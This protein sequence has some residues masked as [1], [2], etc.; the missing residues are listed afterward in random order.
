[1]TAGPSENAAAAAAMAAGQEAELRHMANARQQH[2]ASGSTVVIE[3]AA[4]P[5][6]T[7]VDW[8]GSSAGAAAPTLV[9]SQPR[10]VGL[11]DH[12]PPD[13]A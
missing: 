5:D 2:E 7:A 10:P 8:P 6:D 1:V 4:G 11:V 9:P 12:G 13:A 3:D